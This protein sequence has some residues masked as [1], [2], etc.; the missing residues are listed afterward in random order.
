VHTLEIGDLGLEIR[1]LT[2]LQRVGASAAARIERHERARRAEPREIVGEPA[3]EGRDRDDR[4]GAV[5]PIVEPVAVAA[6]EEPFGVRHRPIGAGRCREVPL[7]P[8]DVRRL[9]LH[10]SRIV[11]DR[12]RE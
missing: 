7:H 8:L 5:D 9:R 6:A 3:G 10:N 4:T 1:P 12:R 11:E 2:R